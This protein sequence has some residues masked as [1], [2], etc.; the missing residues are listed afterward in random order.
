ML[1]KFVIMSVIFR[2]VLTLSIKANMKVSY[3]PPLI[4]NLFGLILY[5]VL[6]LY[7]MFRSHCSKKCV[8]DFM[9]YQQST[10]NE[11][12]LVALTVMK[13][14]CRMYFEKTI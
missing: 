4:Y 13:R 5:C 12:I 8:T 10:S 1:Y 11:M 7:Q 14:C 6:I 2:P 3:T 9:N